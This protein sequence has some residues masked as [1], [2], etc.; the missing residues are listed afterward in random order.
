M[1]RI[2]GRGK[3]GPVD[4]GGFQLAPEG[5]HDFMIEELEVAKPEG[6]DKTNLRV[7][8]RLTSND[9]N[10]GAQISMFFVIEGGKEGERK[11]SEQNMADLLS[12]IPTKDGKNTIEDALN[13]KYPT[14]VSWLSPTLVEV[15]KTT[16][17]GKYVTCE[18]KHTK[19]TKNPEQIFANVQKVAKVGTRDESA[20]SS[21]KKS[22]VEKSKTEEVE[23]F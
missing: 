21:L 5:W 13:S 12:V 9:D 14:E 2:P 8:F 11:R 16:L 3:E 22:K 19:S 17:P 15:Y 1:A 7:P 6:K 10:D 23:D 20:K 4:V 18:V